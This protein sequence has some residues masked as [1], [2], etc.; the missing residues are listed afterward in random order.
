MTGGINQLVWTRGENGLVIKKQNG[1]GSLVEPAAE[2]LAAARALDV[3]RASDWLSRKVE[4]I[5]G[6][7]P[8]ESQLPPLIAA[9]NRLRDALCWLQKSLTDTEMRKRLAAAHRE[10]VEFAGEAAP[11][12]IEAIFNAGERLYSTVNVLC[13]HGSPYVCAKRLHPAFAARL[14]EPLPEIP[15]VDATEFTDQVALAVAGNVYSLHQKLLVAICH[16]LRPLPPVDPDRAL[17]FLEK[18]LETARQW[19]LTTDEARAK[20]CFEEWQAGKT[21]KEINTSLKRHPA[22]EHFDNE[23]SVRGPINSWAKR[24]KVQPR[25]GQR[26]RRKSST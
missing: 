7:R 26:G 19:Q 20:F 22:W 14:G 15:S 17:V 11:S 4:Q 6:R 21:L 8:D 1:D 3:A 24:I 23:K 5:A 2:E 12:Y 25:P 16:Q 13:R 18:E 9:G 10:P